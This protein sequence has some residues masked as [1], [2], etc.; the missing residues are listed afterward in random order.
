MISN[1][2][3]N[4]NNVDGLLTVADEFEKEI[5]VYV[6]FF[7]MLS[8]DDTVLLAETKEDLQRQLNYFLDYCKL[9]KLNVN[10]SKTKIVI[11][12]KG[13]DLQNIYFYIDETELEIVKDFKYLGVVFSRSGSFLNTK[14]KKNNSLSIKQL[15]QCIML[16]KGQDYIICLLIVN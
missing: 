5:G 8:A 6:K 2:F 3:L 1:I 11:F 14:K 7:L 12:S 9:W 15:Q 16:L 4:T 13:R 10:A